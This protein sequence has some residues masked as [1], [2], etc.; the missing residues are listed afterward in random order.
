M[1]VDLCKSGK[2]A[3]EMIR[4]KDYDIVLMDH[5]MPEMDGV[6]ATE[7]IR[8]LGKIDPYYTNVPIIA[9]TADAVSGMKEMFLNNG[10]ND[11][12][13]KPID[14]IRL[15]TIL[16][17]WIPK[18]KQIINK[19]E[20]KKAVNTNQLSSAEI[21]IDGLDVEKGISLTGGSVELYYKAL[22]AFY[23]DGRERK[24]EILKCLDTGNLR[25]FSTHTHGLKSALAIIGADAASEMA[26]ALEKAGMRGDLSFMETAS[27][28]FIEVL[29]QLLNGIK[30]VLST[31]EE[32][33]DKAG[34][35]FET[36]L[37]YTVLNTL[38]EALKN[39]DAG[40]VN[41]TID[42]L[43]EFDCPDDIKAIVKKIS[44]HIIMVEY[45]QAGKLIEFIL[46]Q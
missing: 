39:V 21:M 7:Q 26:Y 17:E 5:R 19:T 43:L 18:E 33:N 25:M 27:K 20:N 1:Q 41:Q 40:L 22:G 4:S 38:L 44:N 10:F 42:I 46:H 32:E 8:A 15:N 2:E 35:S 34:I 16:E 36:E 12:F 30:D 29:E 9:L 37:F 14:V 45:E 24:D 28:Q 3:I 13:S 31:N 23:D 11:F 6:Q